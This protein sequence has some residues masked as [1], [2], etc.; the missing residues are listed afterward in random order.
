MSELKGRLDGGV[1]KGL[2]FTIPVKSGFARIEA[3]FS[4]F[5]ASREGVYW[6]YGNVYDGSGEPLNWWKHDA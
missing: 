5:A 1:E 4:E 6:E 2:V 3:I